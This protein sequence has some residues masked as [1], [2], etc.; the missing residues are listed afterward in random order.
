L[1]AGAA[2]FALGRMTFADAWPLLLR[3]PVEG[4]ATIALYVALLSTAWWLRGRPEG[5]EQTLLANARQLT[6]RLRKR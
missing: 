6:T 4:L 1:A 2:T 5:A 3:L